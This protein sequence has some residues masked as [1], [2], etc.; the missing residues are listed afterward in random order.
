M[1]VMAA[2]LPPVATFLLFITFYFP[3]LSF[4]CWGKHV[5]TI[6]RGKGIKKLVMYE[7]GKHQ[8]KLFHKVTSIKESSFSPVTSLK[9][10]QGNFSRDF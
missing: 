5:I 2:W 7:L 6:S 8:K 9:R 1:G 10:T 4:L 3:F